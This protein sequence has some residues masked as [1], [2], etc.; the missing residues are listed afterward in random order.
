MTAKKIVIT[1]ASTYGV[2]NHGDDAML[3]TL[4]QGLKKAYPDVEITFICRH[5]DPDFDAVFGFRS[6]K[7]LDHDS[8]ELAR[9][10]IFWGMNQ[11]DPDNHL[12]AI[13]EA[14][15]SAD[16]LII[17]GNC[18]MEIFPNGFLQGVSS[19]GATLATLAKFVGTPFALYGVNVVSEIKHETTQAHTRFLVGNAVSVTMRETSGKNYLSAI[20][21][22][23]NQIHVL[24]D[25]AFGIVGQHI[26][27]REVLA[28]E[29]IYVEG[30]P[31]VGVAFRYEYWQGDES[32]FRLI[33]R[34]LAQVLDALVEK[35]DVQ[36]LFVPNCT[37]TEGNEWQDDRVVHNNVRDCMKHKSQ[38]F[39]VNADLNVFETF[40][41]FQLLDMHISNRRHSCIF[42]ALNNIPFVAIDSSL[43]GHM[44]PFLQD[45]GVPN[46]L[47]DIDDWAGVESLAEKTWKGRH[48]IKARMQSFTEYL[49]AKALTHTSRIFGVLK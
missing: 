46:Q 10:R 8:K 42:A 12:R 28:K 43:I 2:K 41:L 18:F 49:R 4:V 34:Q 23:G 9:G 6:I 48:S 37:Y 14:L 13:T 20:G 25:P 36:I 16:L 38:A 1:G 40:S 29:G 3:A 35:L 26:D 27:G 39:S 33:G 31:V 17:G 21:V 24:G 7:N 11:G 5:P 30:R 19:Y 32:K 45:L 47:A 22:E 15:S 44:K